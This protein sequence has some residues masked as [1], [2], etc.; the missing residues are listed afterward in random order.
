MIEGYEKAVNIKTDLT[1]GDVSIKD[2]KDSEITSKYALIPRGIMI[3]KDTAADDVE[4]VR[5]LLI[6]G[7]GE[8]T[9]YLKV[10]V[11][12]PLRVTKVFKAD[13]TTADIFLL[14]DTL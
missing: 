11:V 1:S 6:G 3:G 13:S 9:F 14:G 5:V 2:K 7:H 4:T 8:L 10:N 12:Y